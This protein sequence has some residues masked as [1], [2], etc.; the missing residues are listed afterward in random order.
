MESAPVK[1]REWSLWVIGVLAFSGVTV[2]TFGH[3]ISLAIPKLSWLVSTVSVPWLGM[4]TG[5]ILTA[6]AGYVFGR[7]HSGPN[8]S[9]PKASVPTRASTATPAFEPDAVQ[10]EVLRVLR[11]LDREVTLSQLIDVTLK[12]NRTMSSREIELGVQRLLRL[13]WIEGQQVWNGIDY[14]PGVQLAERGMAFA[15][16]RGFPHG[17]S[18]A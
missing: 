6:L 3:W 2:S 4:A 15:L 10:T 16:S 5:L 9:V 12:T 18:V 11:F 1:F 17:R 8:K 14:E 7:R 13:S